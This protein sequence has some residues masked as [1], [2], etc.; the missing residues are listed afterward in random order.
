MIPK[1][2]TQEIRLEDGR[3]I[4]LETGKLAKQFKD[5]NGRGIPYVLV[6]GPDEAANGTVVL[7][8]LSTGEQW[9]GP[10]DQAASQLT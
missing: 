5:A 8:N 1:T 9:T 3:T 6:C 2:F 7:K 4:K 10:A